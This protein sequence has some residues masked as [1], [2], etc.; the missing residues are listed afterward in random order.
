MSASKVNGPGDAVVCEMIKQ[1]LQEKNLHSYDVFPGTLL[2]AL[3]RRAVK[4]QL[5]H[6]DNVREVAGS[7]SL[8]RLLAWNRSVFSLLRVATRAITVYN[9]RQCWKSFSAQVQV[10]M[11]TP[12]I[13]I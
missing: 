5:H 2:Q 3:S 12:A 6:D 4:Q 8:K 7:F 10:W 9:C 1:F 13:S 11:R